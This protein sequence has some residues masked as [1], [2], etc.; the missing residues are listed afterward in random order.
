M[1]RHVY[2]FLVEFRHFY[3]NLRYLHFQN[4][5]DMYK[6]V[7]NVLRTA[8]VSVVDWIVADVSRIM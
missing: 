6:V 5:L 8:T 2:V 1:C 4:M 7:R 3:V